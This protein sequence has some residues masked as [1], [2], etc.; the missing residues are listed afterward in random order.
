LIGAADSDRGE[1]SPGRISALA[2][3]VVGLL[4][5]AVGVVGLTSGNLLLGLAFGLIGVAVVGFMA[6]SLTNLHALRWNT[7]RVEGP[8]SMFGLT[9]GLGRT[10]IAWADIRRTGDTATGYWYVESQDGRRI[11]WSYLYKGWRTFRDQLKRHK[12]ELPL[13]DG[14]SALG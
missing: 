10:Q 11:Y 6:P 5:A 4:L 7:D 1:I 3:I 9:L 12:P 2:T 8:A 14:M 13:P